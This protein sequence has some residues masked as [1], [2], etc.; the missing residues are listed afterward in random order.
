MWNLNTV[1]TAIS[2]HTVIVKPFQTRIPQPVAGTP[3]S[4]YTYPTQPLN[5]TRRLLG[6]TLR[7]KFSQSNLTRP[8]P[9]NTMILSSLSVSI[10]SLHHLK[11]SFN[12]LPLPLKSSL[13]PFHL[14][15]L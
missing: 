6:R 12:E 7:A 11:I 2:Q 14:I 1:L 5:S 9:H 3:K 4:S 15:F 10:A 13:Q 8:F